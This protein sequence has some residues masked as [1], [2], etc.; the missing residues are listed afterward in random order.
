MTFLWFLAVRMAGDG[1]GWEAGGGLARRPRLNRRA[2][3][4]C[5]AGAA[6][7]LSFFFYIIYKRKKIILYECLDIFQKVKYKD[8][9]IRTFQGFQ[10]C[11]E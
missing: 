1:H 11:L 9:L 6:L 8:W 10:I 7:S 4:T 5:S 3:C 2:G